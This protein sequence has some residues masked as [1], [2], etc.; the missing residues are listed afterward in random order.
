MGETGQVQ[1]VPAGDPALAGGKGKKC[2]D[3]P[4][5]VFAENKG[6]LA[7]RAQRVRVGVGIGERD[8]E[9]RAQPRERGPQLVGG[10]RDEAR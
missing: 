4:F 3:E 9:Q 5:L 2:T 8:F 6:F 10:V 7:D 1:G